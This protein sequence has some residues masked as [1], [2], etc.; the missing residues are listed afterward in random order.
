MRHSE[1]GNPYKEQIA[2]LLRDGVE[3]EECGQTMVVNH[4]PNSAL[5]NGVK[6]NSGANFRIVQL[7]QEGFV[8]LQP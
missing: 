3:I 6:V 4:W 2:A 8:Q 1:H 7:V 5:L